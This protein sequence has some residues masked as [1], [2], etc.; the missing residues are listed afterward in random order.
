MTN[1][2]H[3]KLISTY[4]AADTARMVEILDNYKGST[5]KKYASDYRTIL[6]WVVDRVQEEKSKGVNP[7]GSAAESESAGVSGDRW[8]G[9]PFG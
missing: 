2:E 9:L 3:D 8:G 6:N 4:G 7:C 1:A 5:G